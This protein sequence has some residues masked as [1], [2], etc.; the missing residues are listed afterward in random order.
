MFYS[1]R[2]SQGTGR[3]PGKKIRKHFGSTNYRPGR[4]GPARPGYPAP[5]PEFSVLAGYRNRVGPNCREAGNP[6]RDANYRPGSRH[7]APGPGSR[8]GILGRFWN[9]VGVRYVLASRAEDSRSSARIHA[10]PHGI[11]QVCCQLPVPAAGY[12][13]RCV[14]CELC[15][16]RTQR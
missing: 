15:S 6:D 10:P 11:G 13:A 5:L 2:K 7:P 9:R 8:P 16:Q 4:T 3:G 12:R 1:I 14:R